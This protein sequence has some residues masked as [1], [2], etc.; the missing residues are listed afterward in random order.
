[1]ISSFVNQT[2]TIYWAGND[3]PPEIIIL[4]LV[5]QTLDN[6]IHWT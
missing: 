4:V 3:L 5:A 1:M 2:F 6:A